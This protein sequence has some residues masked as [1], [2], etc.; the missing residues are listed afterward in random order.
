MLSGDT[1]YTMQ[2]SLEDYIQLNSLY[3]GHVVQKE[4]PLSFK[5][6]R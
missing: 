1:I 4:C 2:S 5:G 6:V 3:L